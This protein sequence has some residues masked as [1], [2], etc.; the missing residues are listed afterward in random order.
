MKY[1]G[2]DNPKKRGSNPSHNPF[3]PP[4]DDE[5]NDDIEFDEDVGID[6]SCWCYDG[7][8]LPGGMIMV[9]RWWS[10]IDDS[11]D[12]ECVGPFIFWNVEEP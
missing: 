5:D 10:P 7:V 6:G 3:T 9:G 11:E 2:S 12:M 1:F 4:A 8:V